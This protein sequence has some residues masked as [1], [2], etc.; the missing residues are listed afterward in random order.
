MAKDTALTLNYRIGHLRDVDLDIISICDRL[1]GLPAWSVD[2]PPDL[3]TQ[4]E[5][6]PIDVFYIPS[7][8]VSVKATCVR[9]NEARTAGR[10]H[11]TVARFYGGL[12]ESSSYQCYASGEAGAAVQVHGVPANGFV[13]PIVN[14]IGF[15][16]I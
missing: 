11:A 4:V 12:V 5:G 15:F 9:T 13:R 16:A 3:Q 14:E 8:L 1:N 7:S 6:A 2:G 10:R